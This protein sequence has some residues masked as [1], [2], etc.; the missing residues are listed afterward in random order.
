MQIKF[1]STITKKLK[2]KQIKQICL[3]KDTTWKYGIKSQINWFQNNVKNQDIH[4]LLY[5]KSKLIGYTLLKKR[6]CKINNLQKKTYL[7]F[8]TCLVRP[9][10][11]NQNFSK[12]LMNFNNIIIKKLNLFS[13]LICNNN[14]I[15]FYNKFSWI[16]LNKKNISIS[17]HNFNSNGMVFNAK[18]K[19]K[20]YTFY[21]KK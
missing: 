2:K 18:G 12:I 5:K 20:K 1:S 15:R 9:E 11:R 16:K 10:F 21:I 19:N 14:L 17:D 7:L 8:D 6:S 3:L 4:N 13:F